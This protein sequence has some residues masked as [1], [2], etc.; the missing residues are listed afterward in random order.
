VTTFGRFGRVVFAAGVVCAVAFGLCLVL[1]DVLWVRIVLGVMAGVNLVQGIVFMAVQ[2]R[3]FGNPHVVLRT[4]REGRV[5]GATIVDVGSTSGRVN[6][7]PIVK[8]TLRLD[9]RTYAVRTVVPFAKAGAVQ[10]GA[11]LPVKLD[12][13][14]TGTCV[15]AW[16]AV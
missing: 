7:N 15:V 6:G 12:P 5:R 16:D 14:G 11:T 13:Q 8:L 3:L 1:F 4:E 9:G 10:P 2:R